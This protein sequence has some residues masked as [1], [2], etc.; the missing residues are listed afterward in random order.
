MAKI[1]DGSTLVDRTGATMGDIVASVRRVTD[2]MADISSA[3]QE[4]STGIEQV[5]TTV[6]HMD[7]STQQNAALVEQAAASAHSM[8][9]QAQVLADAVRQFIV[10]KERVAAAASR[11]VPAAQAM[12]EVA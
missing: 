5:S 9:E 1:H 8:E 3:S 7:E 6:A 4:Q 2:I 10:S 12:A 11:P